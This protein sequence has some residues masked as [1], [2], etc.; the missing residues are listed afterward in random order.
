MKKSVGLR[1]ISEDRMPTRW[2]K[3]HVKRRNIRGYGEAAYEE[4]VIEGANVE[5]GNG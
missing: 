4:T 1:Y 5:G 3:S 2:E